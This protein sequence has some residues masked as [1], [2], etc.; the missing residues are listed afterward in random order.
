VTIDSLRSGAPSRNWGKERKIMLARVM[1]K[2]VHLLVA[3]LIVVAGG[4]LWAGDETSKGLELDLFSPEQ[5][6]RGQS[7]EVTVRLPGDAEVTGAEVRPPEGVTVASIAALD[8]EADQGKR[9]W[10][11]VIDVDE[12]ATPGER[13][14]VLTTSLGPTTARKVVLPPHV[15]VLSDFK[16]LSATMRPLKVEFSFILTDAEGD[17]GSSPSLLSRMRCG[18]RI[19]G[20]IG[21][22]TPGPGGLVQASMGDPNG[23]LTEET[24][25]ELEL[26]VWDEKAYEGRLVTDVR[27]EE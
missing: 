17:L 11:I 3:P 5:L 7:T 13:E 23:Y 24:T 4:V 8:Q 1:G 20:T 25:C 22:V 2:I 14:V 12:A 19:T 18:D 21:D 16:L 15:P 26:T 27:F 9:R 10:L 6:T